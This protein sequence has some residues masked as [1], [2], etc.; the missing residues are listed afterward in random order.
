MIHAGILTKFLKMSSEK[1]S[2]RF[3]NF[4]LDIKRLVRNSGRSNFIEVIKIEELFIKY[5]INVKELE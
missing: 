1:E 3:K 2:E 4:I 5:N